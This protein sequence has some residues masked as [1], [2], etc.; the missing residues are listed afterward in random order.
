MDVLSHA[1]AGKLDSVN[2]FAEVLWY[3]DIFIFLPRIHKVR[4]LILQPD[5]LSPRVNADVDYLS[6][7]KQAKLQMPQC[8][9]LMIDIQST[10][11][12]SGEIDFGYLKHMQTLSDTMKNEVALNTWLLKHCFPASE[13]PSGTRIDYE[14]SLYGM[15]C[16]L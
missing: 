5:G 12:R 15:C 6:R 4:A 8:D 11:Y 16:A 2:I 7:I 9:H 1:C 13:A 14:L 3:L 10:R